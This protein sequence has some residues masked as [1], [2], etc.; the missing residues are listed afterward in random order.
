MS[1]MMMTATVMASLMVASFS[2]TPAQG[3]ILDRR[4]PPIGLG[5][6]GF[7]R[8]EAYRAP[9][10]FDG[11]GAVSPTSAHRQRSAFHGH[12]GQVDPY[13]VEFGHPVPGGFPTGGFPTGLGFGSPGFDGRGGVR[14]A[15]PPG[16]ATPVIGLVDQLIGEVGAFLQVFGPTAHIVP[17]GER[18]YRDALDLYQAAVGFR[19]AALSG[20]PPHELRRIHTQ[21]DRSCGRLVGRVNSVAR[22]RTGPNIEQVR[23]IGALCHQL[24]SFL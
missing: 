20:A 6:P 11:L 14:G 1:R 9:F 10:G 13:G 7:D 19:Q 18:M 12:P 8:Y 24:R 22:C 21:M 3:Q 5:S 2:G 15:C 17:Q 4:L 23:Y 16:A